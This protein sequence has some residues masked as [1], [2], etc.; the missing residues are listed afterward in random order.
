MPE[1]KA[2]E[3]VQQIVEGQNLE[4]R[5]TLRKYEQI[6]EEQRKIIQT[7]RSEVLTGALESLIDAQQPELYWRLRRQFGQELT[8]E[9]ERLITLMKIDE[10]WADYLVEAWPRF[11]PAFTGSRLPG[12]I[13]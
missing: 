10:L 2:I 3:H 8:F 5:Q 7:M 12:T 4:I 9:F 11:G 6:I 13:R 1:G